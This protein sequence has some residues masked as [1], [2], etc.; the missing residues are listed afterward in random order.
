MV[1]NQPA[2]SATGWVDDLKLIKRFDKRGQFLIRF[3]LESNRAD[4]ISTILFNDQL[5]GT[6]AAQLVNKPVKLQS[7]AIVI[8]LQTPLTIEIAPQIIVEFIN[9]QQVISGNTRDLTISEA[10][11]VGL[12]RAILAQNHNA[13]PNAN[14]QY[15]NAPL[16]VEYAIGQAPN[17]GD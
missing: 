6:T 11:E 9:Y 17:S 12:I 15:I 13:N 10:A 5:Q 8:N 3:V 2:P 16:K 4:N 7:D 1:N 14:P